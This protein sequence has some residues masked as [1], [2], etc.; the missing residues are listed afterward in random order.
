MSEQRPGCKPSEP[1]ARRASGVLLLLDPATPAGTALR[2][3]LAAVLAMAL[4]F[5]L[6][7]EVPALAVVFVLARGSAGALTMVLG[8]I[9]G[10]AL[11]ILLLALFD[12]SS[13]A[14][15]L[16][17]F[18]LTSLATYASLGRRF[19]YA[20][21]QGLLSFLILVGQGLDAPDAAIRHAFHDLANVVVAAFAA[22]VAGATQPV[23]VAAALQETLVTTLRGCGALVGVADGGSAALVVRLEMLSRRLH[24]LLAT[25]WPTRQVPR[26]RQRVLAAAV[27]ASD[28][29][30]RHALAF[31]AHARAAEHAGTRSGDSAATRLGAAL[32]AA[33]DRIAPLL[34]PSRAGAADQ[35][36]RLA[37]ARARAAAVR[38]TPA[39]DAASAPA[40]LVA[41]DASA[42][43][44]LAE[45]AV[46]SPYLGPG[47]PA[48]AEPAR[49]AAARMRVLP[50]LDRFRLRHAVKS[51]ASYLL[52]LWA[53]IA[54]DWG[55]IVPALVVAVL[56]ATLATPLGAT[57]RKAALRIGGVLAGGGV[58]LL[59]AV[60]LLPFITTLPAICAVAGVALFGFLWVQQHHES[61]AFAAL[62]AAIAFTLTLVHG[63]GPSQSWREPL[64]SLIGLAFGITMVVVVMHAVWPLD[65]ATS[66]HR[67][68]GDLLARAGRRAAALL[69]RG[70][71]DATLPEDDVTAQREAA[72]A[73]AERQHA[74]GFAHEVALYGAQFGRPSAHLAEL[75]RLIVELDALMALLEGPLRPRPRPGALASEIARELRDLGDVLERTCRALAAEVIALPGAGGQGDGG[76]ML[77]ELLARTT[78]FATR[79]E[80]AAPTLR[81]PA[82]LLQD[83]AGLLAALRREL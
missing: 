62:Q 18:V 82:Q 80:H 75:V 23:A 53:W 54:A 34:A 5:A 31:A 16:A 8:A 28:A 11:A 71:R 68:L 39:E 81:V 70:A 26:A 14:F 9:A 63:T 7:I 66:A 36:E 38:R 74:A 41:L 24:A 56:V 51:A 55:A 49:S 40:G 6:H 15:S 46:L 57:L 10:S 58:G 50:P 45:L 64:D 4:A 27:D 72:A 52:V 13:L 2:T 67:V 59:I 48:G 47:A 69:E 61:L 22:F 77:A 42:R 37:A 44:V 60:F 76:R 25:S 17:L 29:V 73:T 3:T 19:P 33:T 43:R 35:P 78:A 65:A 1:A 12:Q 20:Y 79:A 30:V 83:A 32:C 21:I